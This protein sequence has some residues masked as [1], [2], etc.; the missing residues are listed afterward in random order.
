MSER[1]GLKPADLPEYKKEL[2]KNERLEL[3][4]LVSNAKDLQEA[5]AAVK[6]RLEE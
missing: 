3:L 6:K 1:K 2:L 5:I 4:Q